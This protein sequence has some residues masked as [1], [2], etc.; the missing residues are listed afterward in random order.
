MKKGATNPIKAY[1][2]YLNTN[3]VSVHFNEDVALKIIAKN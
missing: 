3:L 1:L 2:L